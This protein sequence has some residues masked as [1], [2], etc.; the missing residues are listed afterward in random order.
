[1]NP[2]KFENR[3]NKSKLFIFYFIKKRD[4]SHLLLTQDNAKRHAD[5]ANCK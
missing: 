4:Q 5:E 2:K 1:M 3:K